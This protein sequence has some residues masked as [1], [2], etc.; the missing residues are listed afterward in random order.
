MLPSPLKIEN[1]VSA[2]DAPGAS[3]HA[4]YLWGGLPLA[5]PEGR[6]GIDTSLPYTRPDKLHRNESLL[7]TPRSPIKSTT[8]PAD[9]TEDLNKDERNKMQIKT[10]PGET[11]TTANCDRGG[12]ATG[13]ENP[14]SEGKTEKRKMKR[15]R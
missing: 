10:E 15:F 13:D 7:P 9:L 4:R 8:A 11:A 12:S 14:Q 2:S 5:K 6:P 3:N 1:A